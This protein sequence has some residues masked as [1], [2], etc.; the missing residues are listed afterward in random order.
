MCCFY[1]GPNRETKPAQL[2]QSVFVLSGPV[3]FPSHQHVPIQSV[4]RS[5]LPK[6]WGQITVG[7]SPSPRQRIYNST[8][9]LNVT[10]RIIIIGFQAH[11][12]M[13]TDAI[14]LFISDERLHSDLSDGC[15][16]SDC[17]SEGCWGWG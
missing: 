15:C 4:C 9:Q 13:W 10:G 8:S 14:I 2:L 17:F 1:H 12:L 5:G 6:I 3:C 16:A 7:K 11:L